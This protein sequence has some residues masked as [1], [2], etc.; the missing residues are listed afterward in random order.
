MVYVL[1]CNHACYA[2]AHHGPTEYS[3]TNKTAAYGKQKQWSCS[4]LN[5][6]NEN[7]LAFH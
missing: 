2:A 6:T 1:S 5:L 7:A 4:H 3:T